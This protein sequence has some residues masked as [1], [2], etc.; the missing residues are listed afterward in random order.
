M[1]H[2]TIQ[3]VEGGESSGRAR[4]LF[5]VGRTVWQSGAQ[6]KNRRRAI[7]RLDLALLVHSQSQSAVGRTQLQTDDIPHLFL[8]LRIVGQL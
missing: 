8:K 5:V 6:K 1:K 2:L 7:E 4:A 3:D